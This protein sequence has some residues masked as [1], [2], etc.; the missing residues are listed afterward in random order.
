MATPNTRGQV[1]YLSSYL[2]SNNN[3]DEP[4]VSAGQVYWL[5]AREERYS[6]PQWIANTGKE[7][8]MD[9]LNYVM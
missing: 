8:L 9:G 4:R 3:T 5:N 6:P 2:N 1:R 7:H